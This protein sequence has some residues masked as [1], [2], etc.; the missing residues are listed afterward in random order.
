MVLGAKRSV[1]RGIICIA[2]R[3]EGVERVTVVSAKRKVFTNS[4]HQVWIRDKIASKRNRIE[5]PIGDGS[6]SG[7]WL[8]T[9]CGNEL[10]LE[11]R[12]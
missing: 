1:V 8:E 7:I 5:E 2:P 12:S 11:D 6:L 9:P 3:V 4:A 10:S